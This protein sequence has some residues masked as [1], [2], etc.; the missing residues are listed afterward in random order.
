MTFS[1]TNNNLVT[2]TPSHLHSATVLSN[3]E[4]G[5]QMH[6]LMAELFPI[7]RSIT[8]NGFRESLAIIA[9]QLPLTIHEVASGT[10][11][12]DWIV[13]REWN[14]RDA[15]IK[16]Q[17][18]RKVIDLQNSSLHVLNYSTPIHCKLSAE[19]L[20]AHL[21][22]LPEH[23]DWIPYRTSYY[24]ERWGF[25]LAHRDLELL[26][27]GEF[28]VC[29]DSTLAPGSLTYGECLLPGDTA[30]EVLLS[31]HACHPSLANDNLSGVVLVTM[32]GRWLASIPRK[33]T[34]R[35]LFIPGA[36]GSITWL[37]QHEA[38]LDRI[39][40]GLVVACV[41]DPGKFHYKQSRRGNAE[42]DQAAIHALS[43]STEPYEIQEFTPYG[44]DERQYCSP[45]INL[46]VGSLNR[47]PH[48]CYPQYHTSADDLSFVTPEGL[49]GSL[50]MYQRVLGILE[51]NARYR[52]LQPKCEPQLGRR[53]LYRS[54]GG[55]PD[56]GQ[57]E[58]AML[59]VL[60]LSD[61]EHSLLD[62]AQRSKIAFPL[63]KDVA[64]A[65]VAAELL[66]ALN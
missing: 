6:A 46:P 8:G 51:N 55:L 38:Q 57:R 4:A 25:C 30:D 12:F 13:P 61:G 43:T 32:L 10:P 21:F 63:V 47:T 11:V 23:P 17:H 58:L 36:I 60:N 16:D 41:G 33:Y 9:R 28:E 50:A 22:T 7:C 62:I 39:K 56:A 3:Q 44:Y 53:G 37:A 14:L 1:E 31:C 34:Y 24:Q 35:L 19:E 42:I 64:D 54:M 26:S 2:A 27:H 52:N 40:H 45:G 18:G 59:W 48:G 29:I 20:R 65:L 15:W 5:V 49:A 66:Q